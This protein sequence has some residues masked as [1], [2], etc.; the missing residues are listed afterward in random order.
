VPLAADIAGAEH[1]PVLPIGRF[2]QI[3]GNIHAEPGTYRFCISDPCAPRFVEYG[4]VRGHAASPLSIM[5]I[6]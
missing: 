6:R 5:R 3:R 2:G 4:P 1:T